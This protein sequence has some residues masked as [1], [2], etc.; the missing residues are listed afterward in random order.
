[1]NFFAAK[2]EKTFQQFDNWFKIK[3]ETKKN[4]FQF[5]F[6]QHGKD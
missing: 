5:L 2:R 6:G 4:V 1:M 3:A